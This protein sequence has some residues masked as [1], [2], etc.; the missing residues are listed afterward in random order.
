VLTSEIIAYGRSMANI[1]STNFFTDEDAL[2]AVNSSWKDIYSVL[3][4]EDDDYFVTSLRLSQ[5]DF[6]PYEG[7]E[8]TYIYSL[9]DDFFRLRLVQ[10]A[11]SGSWFSLEKMTLTGFGSWPSGSGY[12]MRGR[13]LIIYDIADHEYELWYYPKPD[14][15]TIVPVDFDLNYPY[16]VI[17]EVMA[18]QVAIEIERKGKQPPASIQTMEARR[19]E[20]FLTF[21]RQLRRDDFQN[22]RVSNV[23][24]SGGSWR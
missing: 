9:P 6:T 22:I 24:P 11:G 15:L 20:L 4:L 16:E 19:N 7:R 18:Y 3:T 17:P 5:A 12:M 1:P 21:R 2:R 23:F 14:T 13:D 10:Y 8:N